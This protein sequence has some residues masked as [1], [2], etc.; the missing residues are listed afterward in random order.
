MTWLSRLLPKSHRHDHHARTLRSKSRR[1]IVNLESLENRTVLSD[2]SV[3]FALPGTL[4][5]VADSHN[6]SFNI[7]EGAAGIVT[8]S[9]AAS[10]PKLGVTT[11][12]GSSAAYT[13]PHAV[14]TINVTLP[15]SGNTDT[16]SLTGLGKTT[17]TTVHNV[18]FTANT[19]TATTVGPNV[20][21]SVSNVDN[22]G[23]L[24]GNF[25]NG[26]LMASVDSSSFA[27]LSILQTGCCP[28]SVSLTNDNVPGTVSVSEGSARHDLI[29]LNND[30]FGST[31]LVQGNSGAMPNCDGEADT[32]SVTNSGVR[33]LTIKQLLDGGAQSF[34]GAAGQSITVD[35]VTVSLTSFGVVTWQG[36]GDGDTATVNAVTTAGII[37][38]NNLVKGP[39]S[40]CITQGNGNGDMA[41]VT[42]TTLPGNISIYQGNGAGDM[43]Q[44]VGD[45]IGF[46]IPFGPYA[47]E[48]FGDVTICQGNGASDVAILDG[49]DVV[50]DVYITQGNGTPFTGCVLPA[51]DIAQI[52]DTTVTS[53]I[54]ITQGHDDGDVG[55]N[56]VA[57]GYDYIGF[58]GSSPVTA[59]G[60]TSVY[61]YGA[62]NMVLLG[63]TSSS[64]STDFLD[65]YTGDGGG[66][67]VWA[68]NTTVF[69]GSYYGN[70]FTIDGGGD[71]NVFDDNG[72][73][74]GVTTSDNYSYVYTGP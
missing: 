20:K 26:Q 34:T 58:M 1:R 45:T 28:A 4:T 9:P 14:T 18:T 51:G 24:T 37:N 41:T 21:L 29:T 54:C 68:T 7:A 10:S 15:G 32:V 30:T 11:I 42:N 61:Q 69:D 39:P 46:W 25:Y 70:D 43:A 71:G 33:D 8:V 49:G 53:D 66:G 55:D 73:N 60:A 13:S 44:V 38:P 6:N 40:I 12:N 50:N 65:I 16:I 56:V 72:G 64:F 48:Y 59:G 17:P 52:N 35:T 57:I 19:S 5:I 27:S 63:D 62:N 67:F 23:A 47:A 74:S 22:N 3:S 2:V 36:N 31:T